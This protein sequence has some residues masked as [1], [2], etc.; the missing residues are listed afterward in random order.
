MQQPLA[1]WNP[2]RGVW[3]KPTVNL[4]CGHSAPYSQTWPASGMTRGGSAYALPT[5]ARHTHGS[6]SSLLP[7]PKATDSHHSSPADLNRN[8]PGLRAL[9]GMLLKTPTAQLA[10]N[11]GSQHPDKRK[12]GGHGPTL[13]DEVEHLLPTPAA[14]EPGGTLEAYHARLKAAD[15]RD[16]TFVPLSMLVTTLLPTPT[17]MDSASIGGS[18]PADVTLT[19]AV[20]RTNLGTTPNPRHSGAPTDPPSSGGRTWWDVPLPLPLSEDDSPPASSNG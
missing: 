3:E 18:T 15:G 12:A 1:T 7:T 4:L 5:S 11:G 6:A 2:A 13:A 19:D 8:A 16:S 10:V 17:A 14:Q 9:P 20:V